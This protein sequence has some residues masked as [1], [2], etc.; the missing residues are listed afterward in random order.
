[1][2]NYSEA[3]QQDETFRGKAS[4]KKAI[5]NV[6][7]AL[8]LNLG[9]ADVHRIFIPFL[10]EGQNLRVLSPVLAY[11]QQLLLEGGFTRD[12]ENDPEVKAYLESVY[13]RMDEIS[14]QID[15]YE[16]ENPTK[17]LTRVDI[18][19]VLELAE[20]FA[21]IVSRIPGE[22]YSIELGDPILLLAKDAEVGAFNQATLT[23]MI[24]QLGEIV[25]RKRDAI[26]T[27]EGRMDF[28][29]RP[30]FRQDMGRALRLNQ[31]D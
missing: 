9:I 25:A 7:I 26:N 15:K 20:S 29:G 16:T 1:M 30:E 13:T 21:S 6:L 23:E 14:S 8:E 11:I 5:D 28:Y 31:I 24:Q 19:K 3:P 22:H 12:S 27:N 10:L 2:S 17:K 18:E 4:Y